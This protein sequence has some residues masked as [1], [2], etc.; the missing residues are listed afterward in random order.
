[1]FDLYLKIHKAH[2]GGDRKTSLR[3]HTAL[4]ALLNQIRQDVEMIIAFEKTI[5]Q[6]RGVI[7]SNACR[8]PTHTPDS[9][10]LALFDT[11]YAELE[12]LLEPLT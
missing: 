5:L 1:M 10:E 9:Y 8:R 2:T 3:L 4:L 7:A 12:P 6:R 11:L